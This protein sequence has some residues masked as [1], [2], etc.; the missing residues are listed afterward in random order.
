MLTLLHISDL[1]FGPPYRA[2]IGRSLLEIAPHLEADIVVASGDFTQ[3]ARPEQFAAARQFLDQLPRLPLIVVPGNHDIPLYRLG[4]RLFS[5]YALYR[6]HI[7]AELDSV[8]RRDDAVIVA[9]NTTD[10]LRAITDGRIK[11]WQLDFCTAGFRDAPA[12]AVKIVVAHHHF[13]PAPDYDHAGDKM[14]GAKAALDRFTELGVDLVLGGHLHRAY[15]G[16]SLDVYPS[17]DRT[18]GIIIVQCGTSTSQRGRAREREKNSFNLI[19]IGDDVVRIT[20]Y[21]HF[22]ETGGFAPV[23]RHIFPRRSRHFFAD[24]HAV[25]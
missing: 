14:A 21:M 25:E 1:H 22:H 4:E 19:K 6:Q 5:P 2:D 3:R 23:S 7:C 15:I 9:L 11:P 24:H 12:M 18:S 13:A 8:L 16:N 17:S 10:P 20:H